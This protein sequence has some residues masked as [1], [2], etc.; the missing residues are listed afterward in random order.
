MVHAVFDVFVERGIA[1]VFGVVAFGAVLRDVRADED[2]DEPREDALLDFAG[3]R[4]YG[5]TA[6]PDF[7]V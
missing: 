2:D 7:V 6:L 4:W 3:A 5:A 1:A